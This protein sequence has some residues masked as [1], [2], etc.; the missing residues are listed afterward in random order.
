MV[1]HTFFSV[2]LV[3]KYLTLCFIGLWGW[4]VGF[5]HN[6]CTAKMIYTYK[7]KNKILR[8]GCQFSVC[9][10]GCYNMREGKKVNKLGLLLFVS[11]CFY[12]FTAP[13][14]PVELLHYVYFLLPHYYFPWHL[15]FFLLFRFLFPKH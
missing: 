15:L 14:Q 10:P 6:M 13:I 5:V 2:L 12:S 11:Y 3:Y 4:W 7:N 8:F 9:S 1:V